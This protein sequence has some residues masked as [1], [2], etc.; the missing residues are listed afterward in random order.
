M[1]EH[2]AFLR[3]QQ[4]SEPLRS[5][6]PKSAQEAESWQPLRRYRA[7]ASRVL[8]AAQTRI[9]CEWA[10]YCDA[11]DGYDHEAEY[12]AVLDHGN[13]LPEKVARTLFP[14]FKDVPYAD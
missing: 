2:P 5:H 9:I 13:K 6:F 12:K 7:L 10:A 4:L 11:V 3:A 14:E 1:S 8:V